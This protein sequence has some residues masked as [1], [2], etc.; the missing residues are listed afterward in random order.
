MDKCLQNPTLSN[1]KTRQKSV[2]PN[3]SSYDEFLD[4]LYNDLEFILQQLTT[5]KDIYY[6]GMLNDTSKGEDLVNTTICNLLEARGWQASHDTSVNGHAD[7][8][9]KLPYFTYLWLG[10][11]KVNNGCQYIM[12][13]LKQLLHRYSTGID[14]QTSGGMLIYIVKTQL[15]QNHIIETWKNSLDSYKQTD[16]C[17][18]VQLAEADNI[19]S[20]PK[21]SLVFYSQ[22]T[23]P[24]SGKDFT[25][26]NM[27]VD[28]RHRP[29][30]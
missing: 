4:E 30:D 20:C 14:N 27:S 13:G 22:H 2:E 16:D 29:I 11:G 18:E 24:S 19:L 23:H 12:G 28:F 3:V 15:T 10:E 8:V 1:L 7:I 5:S 26:R 6:Q 9:V 21:N 25:V 17:D